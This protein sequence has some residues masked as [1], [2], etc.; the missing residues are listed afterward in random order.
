MPFFQTKCTC[1]ETQN[2]TLTYLVPFSEFCCLTIKLYFCQKLQ[3][4]KMMELDKQ[5]IPIGDSTEDKKQRKQFIID[6]YG[7]WI[8]AN[9]TKQIYNQ[10]LQTFIVVR[11]L[12]IEETAQHASTTYKSTIAITFF[13]L[14]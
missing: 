8:A 13:C 14:K 11:F 7:K 4:Q 12:S 1:G 6:F 2:T 9:P 10:S 3:L 5:G